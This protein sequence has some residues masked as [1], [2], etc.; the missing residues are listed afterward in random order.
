MYLRKRR[1]RE[2]DKALNQKRI[3]RSSA[4]YLHNTSI[5]KAL[6]LGQTWVYCEQSHC[7]DTDSTT[8]VKRI[9]KTGQD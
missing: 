7:S 9:K 3:D 5:P 1:K 6:I 2:G 4:W 8:H